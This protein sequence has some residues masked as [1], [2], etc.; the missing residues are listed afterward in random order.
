MI[1]VP[2]L[3]GFI[4]KWYLGLGALEEGQYWVI[5]VLVGSS[6]LNATYFLPVFYAAWFKEPRVN[7]PPNVPMGAWKLLGLYSR[8]LWR[9]RFL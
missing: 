1:G 6:L 4:S 3:A 9:L 8:R 2:P 5:L 7:G